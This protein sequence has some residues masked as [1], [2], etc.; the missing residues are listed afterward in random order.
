MRGENTYAL[1]TASGTVVVMIIEQI[2][3]Y[4]EGGEI[5][6]LLKARRA[7]SHIRG[8]LELPP[9][10]ILLADEGPVEAP[11]IV[12]QCLYEDE[13][14]MG[15]VE[16]HLIGDPDYESARERLGALAR[17]VEVELYIIDEE[18]AG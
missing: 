5:E 8:Q 10:H 11:C 6:A 9:G 4:L 12:W 13:G 7:V 15:M 3:Y 17:H 2:R 18:D 16:T 14:E 1:R